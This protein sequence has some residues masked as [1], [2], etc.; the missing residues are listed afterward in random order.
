MQEQD[1]AKST[2]SPEVLEIIQKTTEEAIQKA[3]ESLSIRIDA[4]QEKNI[5]KAVTQLSTHQIIRLGT[6]IGTQTALDTLKK[7]KE[8]RFKQKFSRRLRNVRALFREYRKLKAFCENAVYKK[9]KENAT[10]IL[11]DL[12]Q[13]EYDDELYIESIKKSTERTYVIINHVDTMINVYRILCEQ[14][15]KPEM[16]RKYNVINEIYLSQDGKTVEDLADELHVSTRSIYN[17]IDDAARAIT[18]LI[19]GVDGMKV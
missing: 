16:L 2:I 3:V 7:E 14:N 11:E 4:D 15:K 12:E 10:D 1:Q 5:I 8:E 9:S 6:E 13:F 18:P 17:D 19:F